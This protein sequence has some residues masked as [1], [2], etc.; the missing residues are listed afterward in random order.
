MLSKKSTNIKRD[1]SNV[2][3]PLFSIPANAPIANPCQCGH[4][5]LP[6]YQIFDSETVEVIVAAGS[7]HDLHHGD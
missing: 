2:R 6:A 5:L 7:C 4:L 3:Y 1:I